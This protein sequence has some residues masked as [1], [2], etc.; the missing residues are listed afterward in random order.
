MRLKDKNAA[1]PGG[2]WYQYEDSEGNRYRVNGYHVTYGS[3]FTNLV[4]GDMIANN[5]QVPDDLGE[6]IEEQICSRA[7]AGFCWQ[8]S[9]DVT[10]NI[11][12]TFAVL[13]DRVGNAIGVNPQFAKKT[14]GC[15]GCDKRRRAMNR[16]L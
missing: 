8:G 9:G 16:V 5:V 1:I 12:H 6:L 2:L 13:G 15:A 4:K 3:Q 7:P 10:R 11:I 14:S